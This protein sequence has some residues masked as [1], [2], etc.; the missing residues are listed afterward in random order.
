MFRR[1]KKNLED[2]NI[3]FILV[4][5][6]YSFSFK[7]LY[8]IF[9]S[10]NLDSKFIIT[11]FASIISF[12]PIYLM[13]K[14]DYINYIEEGEDVAFKT[15][16]FSFFIMIFLNNLSYYL[17]MG[18]E[19]NMNKIGYTIIVKSTVNMGNSDY[20]VRLF[21]SILVAPVVEELI[22]RDYF[23]RRLNNYGSFFGIIISALFFGIMHENFPQFALGFSL[24]ILFALVYL[25]TGSV[26][27]VIILHMLN[28]LYGT[29]YN[30]F[31]YGFLAS[32]GDLQRVLLIELLVFTIL[33]I[34]GLIYFI[35]YTDATKILREKKVAYEKIYFKEYIRLKSTWLILFGFIVAIID[36][37]SKI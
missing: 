4:I 6:T 10:I 21:Y 23:F 28:N 14:K 12:I 7:F 17:T 33:A 18:I 20:I 27:A 11:I 3:L 13:D 37:I 35:N 19:T 26:K 30:E 1:N 2:I 16:L 25:I 5:L 29:L 24:G 9:N 34:V 15:Y 8:E 36:S 32:D 31:I 22:Y